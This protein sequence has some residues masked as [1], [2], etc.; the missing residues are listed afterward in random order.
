MK[1]VTEIL[2]NITLVTANW[3]EVSNINAWVPSATLI[4]LS[5]LEEKSNE[6]LFKKIPSNVEVALLYAKCGLDWSGVDTP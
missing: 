5:S 3:R 4:A 2:L 1:C 6:I